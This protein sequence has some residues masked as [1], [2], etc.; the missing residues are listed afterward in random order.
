[1]R[2]A[3]GPKAAI[4]LRHDDRAA[5]ALFVG[6]DGPL[7]VLHLVLTLPQARRRGVGL[8]GLRHAAAWADGHGARHLVLPVE[9]SNEPAL[10]LYAR[11]GLT[12]RGGYRY[13]STT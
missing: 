9:A 8:L 3:P 5:G 12:R 10:A 2:R 4:L 11:A 7:A 6:L 1:M 13:W